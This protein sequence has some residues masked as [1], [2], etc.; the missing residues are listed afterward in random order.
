VTIIGWYCWKILIERLEMRV[1][2]KI[3][4]KPVAYKV[5]IVNMGERA[6][7]EIMEE[8]RYD[9]MMQAILRE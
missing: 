5:S 4:G 2:F 3:L 7:P 8:T 9:S 6:M 1:C